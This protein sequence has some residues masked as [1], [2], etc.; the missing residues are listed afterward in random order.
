[1]GSIPKIQLSREAKSTKVI[2]PELTM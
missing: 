2:A 1:M